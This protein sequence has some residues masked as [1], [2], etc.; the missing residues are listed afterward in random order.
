MRKSETSPTKKEIPNLNPFGIFAYI[1]EP[2]NKTFSIFI[3][4]ILCGFPRLRRG[5]KTAIKSEVS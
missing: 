3:N 5:K 1:K 2:L 4:V